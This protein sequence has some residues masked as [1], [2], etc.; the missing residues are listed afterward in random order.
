MSKYTIELR[1]ICTIIGREEVEKWFTN[2]ELSD[3]LTPNQIEVVTNAKLFDKNKLAEMIVDNY[4]MR[5]IG[6][7]TIELF[8]HY[9]KIHMKAIMEIALPKIYSISLEYDPLVN[10]NYTETFTRNIDRLNNSEGTSNTTDNQ[11]ATGLT[12]N[13]DTPQGEID[14]GDILNGK[15]ASSTSAGE[16]SSNGTSNINTQ[17]RETSNDKENYSK[18]TEGNSGV[19]STNQK[20]IE[21]YRNNIIGINREIIEYLN[22][23]FIGIY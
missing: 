22:I 7:E 10:V 6:F 3:Y 5:E 23:L 8:K 13:S 16:R 14:K 9:A 2:Y 20:L 15:Y 21:Q 11:N 18:H 4:F 1:K 17:A 12:I 19:L